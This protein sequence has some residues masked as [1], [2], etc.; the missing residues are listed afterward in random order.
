MLEVTSIRIMGHFPSEGTG[1][2]MSTKRI[3]FLKSQRPAL[4]LRD[5]V[6]FYFRDKNFPCHFGTKRIEK[7]IFISLK[8]T[9]YDI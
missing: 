5:I 8:N 7:N 3:Y 4:I 1:L 2:S 6:G 9:S